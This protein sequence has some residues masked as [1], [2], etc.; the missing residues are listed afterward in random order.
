[1][2]S[3]AACPLRDRNV[4]MR[5]KESLYRRVFV[6]CVSRPM[7][8]PHKDINLVNLC[9]RYSATIK[10]VYDAFFTVNP[11]YHTQIQNQPPQNS[12]QFPPPNPKKKGLNAHAHA[13]ARNRIHAQSQ[14]Q[15]TELGSYRSTHNT[16]DSLSL[17]LSVLRLKNANG[18]NAQ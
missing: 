4:R 6:L 10:S 8:Q 14:S 1:M 9:D 12:I 18:I 7:D 17:S 13:H 3:I 16:N 5:R 15:S 2:E 11:G